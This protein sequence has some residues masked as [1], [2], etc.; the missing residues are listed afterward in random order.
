MV[1][2][3]QHCMLLLQLQLLSWRVPRVNT[4]CLRLLHFLANHLDEP[5]QPRGIALACTPTAIGGLSFARPR[6]LPGACREDEKTFFISD[7]CT[8][9][10]KRAATAPRLKTAHWFRRSFTTVQIRP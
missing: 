2:S 8:G 5:G 9:S 6:S 1:R 7:L 10:L 3:S 4:G